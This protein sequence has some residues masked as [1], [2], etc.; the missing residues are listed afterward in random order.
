M[1]NPSDPNQIV[2]FKT[3]QIPE[4]Q[5]AGLPNVMTD[6]APAALEIPAIGAIALLFANFEIVFLLQVCRLI[7][8]SCECFPLQSNITPPTHQQESISVTC[9]IQT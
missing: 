8:W 2:R 3:L 1:T 9:R 6:T 4:S 7:G 5:R